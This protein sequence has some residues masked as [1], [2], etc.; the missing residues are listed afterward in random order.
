MWLLFTRAGEEMDSACCPHVAAQVALHLPMRAKQL[1]NAV[2]RL[3]KE[4]QASSA[5]KFEL[6]TISSWIM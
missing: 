3:M 5:S 6:M 2:I 1:F 4:S